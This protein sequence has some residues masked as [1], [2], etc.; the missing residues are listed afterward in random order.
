M[1]SHSEKA[2]HAPIIVKVSRLIKRSK[3]SRNSTGMWA[4][5][6]KHATTSMIATTGM[7]R[8]WDGVESYNYGVTVLIIDYES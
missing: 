6:V 7:V 8:D 1:A 2:V 3:I 5:S 4:T